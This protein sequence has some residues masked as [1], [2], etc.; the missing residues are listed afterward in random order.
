MPSRNDVKERLKSRVLNRCW[1][2]LRKCH[3]TCTFQYFFLLKISSYSPVQT[4]LV[5]PV[6]ASP[7]RA[8]MEAPS[9]L[10]LFSVQPPPVYRH[11]ELIFSQPYYRYIGWV[12]KYNICQRLCCPVNT[13]SYSGRSSTTSSAGNDQGT[14]AAVAGLLASVPTDNRLGW[15][16]AMIMLII[17]MMM[18]VVRAVRI[19]HMHLSFVS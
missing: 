18:M 3:P 15:M 14:L 19:G 13:S 12:E 6:W 7:V 2:K 16:A 11:L 1:C 5:A 10:G 17:M 4:T 9:P 8:E